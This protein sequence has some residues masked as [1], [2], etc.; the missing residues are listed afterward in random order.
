MNEKRGILS[1]MPMRRPPI[2]YI[3]RTR[4]QY[5]ALGYP[6]Y[7]WVNKSDRPPMTPIRKPVSESRLAWSADNAIVSRG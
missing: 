4:A 6:A 2:D 3:A 5:D 1:D 7:R